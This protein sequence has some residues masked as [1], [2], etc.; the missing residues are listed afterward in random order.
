MYN[1]LL[2]TV[3]LSAKPD[4]LWNS[5]YSSDIMRWSDVPVR[6]R[7]DAFSLIFSK[8]EVGLQLIYSMF[9]SDNPDMRLIKSQMRLIKS[10]DSYTIF[11]QRIDYEGVILF[12][13]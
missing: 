2:F 10:A 1:C 11:N 6:I 4:G 13:G 3:M 12:P 9:S 5:I 8:P 7:T